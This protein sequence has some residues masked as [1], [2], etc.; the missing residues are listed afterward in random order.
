MSA[1]PIIGH[2]QEFNSRMLASDVVF[3]LRK[4]MTMEI[5]MALLI[6]LVVKE[7]ATKLRRVYDH[8]A[9]SL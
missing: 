8:H 4:E 2:I 9:C 3:D 5:L 1:E 7:V 6:V